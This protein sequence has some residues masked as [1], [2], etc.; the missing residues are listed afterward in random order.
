[1]LERAYCL[2][3]H[4][5]SSTVLQ[6]KYDEPQAPACSELSK[7]DF[8]PGQSTVSYSSRGGE[9]FTSVASDTMC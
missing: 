1:M 5:V 8:N 4:D 2:N 3:D 9:H 7:V 6:G